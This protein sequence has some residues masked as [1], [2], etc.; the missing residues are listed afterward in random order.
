[1][2]MFLRLIKPLVTLVSCCVL[3]PSVAFAGWEVVG[4]EKI[5]YWKAPL[6]SEQKAGAII[7]S[8]A[9]GACPADYSSVLEGISQAGYAVFAPLH[10]DS[11]CKQIE[12]SSKK[13]KP[14]SADPKNSIGAMHLRREDI[15]QMLAALRADARFTTV[16]LSRVGLAGHELGG[17]SALAI[18]A[19]N[20]GMV[21]DGVIA[22]LTFSPD[23]AAFEVGNGFSGISI[24]VMYQSGSM[25]DGAR[26]VI[27]RKEGGF[28]KTPRGKYYV[29]FKN[30]TRNAWL[31]EKP[32][33][34]ADITRYSI[35]FF[36]RY[37]KDK[38]NTGDVLTK[39]TAS[40]Q[41]LRFFAA[42]QKPKKTVIAAS[43]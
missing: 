28:D 30:A 2:L 18:A 42:C 34:H 39:P 15:T 19:G 13:E 43:K 33:L 41:E 21:L 36:D 10:G 24:P 23:V 29:E 16:D 7:F 17:A 1:M 37:I 32:Q 6:T 5:A 26:E 4:G 9:Y 25:D 20:R 40:I 27:S 8:H 12:T 31:N 22:A 11:N 35:G 3:I 14:K 38:Q